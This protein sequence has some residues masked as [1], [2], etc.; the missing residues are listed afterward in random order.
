[1]MK[2][3]GIEITLDSDQVSKYMPAAVAVVCGFV[4]LASNIL[5]I[6]W[7]YSLLFMLAVGFSATV[8]LTSVMDNVKDVVVPLDHLDES[9]FEEIDQSESMLLNLETIV[10][11]VNSLSSKQVEASRIQTEDAVTAILNRFS[12]IHDDLI[13]YSKVN[14]LQDDHEVQILVAS[15]NDILVSFQFQDRTSQILHHVSN[16]LEIFS[17]EIKS[18]QELRSKDGQPE[19]DKNQIIKKLTAGFSTAEQRA[20]VSGGSEVDSKEVDSKNS[21]EFF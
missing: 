5:E 16:S 11:L 2:I 12:R 8:Y 4:F 17:N 9:V 20:M 10:I 1:M 6:T 15:L 18:I 7:G 21:I 14:E 13:T 19:Y 3:P